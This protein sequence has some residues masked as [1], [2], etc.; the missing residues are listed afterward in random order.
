[1][2]YNLHNSSDYIKS[3][4][5]PPKSL[6]SGMNC[7]ILGCCIIPYS[8]WMSL[9]YRTNASID[10]LNEGIKNISAG[11]VDYTEG[12]DARPTRRQSAMKSEAHESLVRG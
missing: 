3:A 10:I 2:Q 4:R 11:T 5:N 8:V 9:S 12:A 6:V 1:M 7:T